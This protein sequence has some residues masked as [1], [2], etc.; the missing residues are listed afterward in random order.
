MAYYL[1]RS[2]VQYDG[3][4]RSKSLEFFDPV[5]YLKKNSGV[6]IQS[7]EKLSFSL[8]SESE[9]TMFERSPVQSWALSVFLN[10][11]NN[12]K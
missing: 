12:I 6:M 5:G 3:D 10:F 8:P 9:T 1:L 11:F 7:E 4:G 2:M